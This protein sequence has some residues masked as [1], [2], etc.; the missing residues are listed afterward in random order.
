M[1]VA[2]DT[3]N[4][5]LPKTGHYVYELASALARLDLDDEF[6]LFYFSRNQRVA[7]PF[8][9][10][11]VREHRIT[12]PLVRLFGLLWRMFPFPTID[13]FMPEVDVYHFPNFF[14]R[15]HRRGRCVLTIHDLSFVRY[16][17]Y[18]E[19]KN[20]AF[21]PGQVKASVR[22]ADRIIADSDFTRREVID[23]YGV[24]ESVV[25]TVHLGVR[26]E[27]SAD[28]SQSVISE[29]RKKYG[30]PE[31][32]VLFVGTIEPRKNL[33]GLIDA[34]KLMR[35]SSPALQDVKLVVCGMPGWLFDETLKQMQAP[36]VA[37]HI[38]RTGYVDA[39]DLPAMYSAADVVALPSWYE[40]FGFPCLEGMA[41]GTPV[42]CSKDSSMSEITGDA[43]ILVDPADTE[44]IAEGLTRI[45]SDSKLRD[46]L[47]EKGLKRAAQFTW[48][49]TAR[50]TYEIYKS[51]L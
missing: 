4:L 24:D 48:E 33:L 28:I 2:I 51:V 31:R 16:P 34:F 44:S 46:D 21:L 17:Q 41:C 18:T 23:I 25:E 30:L 10:E 19:P 27:F 20:L 5:Q 43:A 12:S 29:T 38:F 1:R 47:V 26:P 14:I 49:K 7:F 36:D 3:Q 50:K 40:G 22:R 35:Q 37:D 39:G 42:L 15:P 45:L 8:L 32:Y 9:N 6:L 13:R 11:S